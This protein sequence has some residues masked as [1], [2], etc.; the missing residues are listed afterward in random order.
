MA[1]A[2]AAFPPDPEPPEDRWDFEPLP[3]ETFQF[4]A[5][6]DRKWDAFLLD[7]DDLDQW[8]EDFLR[9]IDV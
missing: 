8:P 3:G 6:D 4:D 7:D 9:R 5:E 1:A 2:R